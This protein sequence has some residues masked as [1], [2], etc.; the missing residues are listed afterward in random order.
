MNKAS[1]L[2]QP[3]YSKKTK[4]EVESM[5]FNKFE[6]LKNEETFHNYFCSYDFHDNERYMVDF[7]EDVLLYYYET[8]FSTFG[9]K[10]EDV[11]SYSKFK[12]KNPIGLENIL[13]ELRKEKKYVTSQDLK[14][15]EF[16]KSK[17]P[18]LYP[19]QGF[20]SGLT[21]G[22]T[23][24]IASGLSSGISYFGLWSNNNEEGEKLKKDEIYINYSMFVEHCENLTDFLSSILK[25]DDNEVIPKDEFI[26]VLKNSS[27]PYT[28]DHLDLCLTFLEKT[29][30]IAVFSVSP[31]TNDIQC[32]KLLKDKNDQVNQK[33]RAIASILIETK[34]LEKR[35]KD[36]EGQKKKY[37]ENAMAALKE[38][39]RTKAKTILMKKKN[40][41]KHIAHYSNILATLED[42]LLTL[43]SME[44]NV[45]AKDILKEAL[46]VT[47][48][49]VQDPEDFDEVVLDFK[50]QR[51][52]QKEVQNIFQ[53]IKEEEDETGLEEEMKKLMIDVKEKKEEVPKEKISFP[54]AGTKEVN[55]EKEEENKVNEKDDLD[56]MLESLQN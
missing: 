46:K 17:F 20:F 7:W 28:T 14:S 15:E 45:Q 39:D 22:I 25:E 19:K 10:I 37:K 27:I 2:S 33:D 24:G 18:E 52:N 3:A 30:K 56:K 53:G 47:K 49:I 34:T 50:E 16:Y 40:I 1:T 13:I 5:V 21:S 11:M 48:E 55:K 9:L 41:E 36:A 4:E 31:E 29:K 26:K 42:N 38:K 51:D 12:G 35:I 6:D 43:K 8:V 54:E 32:I 44:S 23:S